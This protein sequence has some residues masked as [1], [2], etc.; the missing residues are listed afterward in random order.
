MQVKQHLQTSGHSIVYAEDILRLNDAVAKPSV[1]TETREVC[2]CLSSLCPQCK[3]TSFELEFLLLL[4]LMHMEVEVALVLFLSIFACHAHQMLSLS[5]TLMLTNSNLC[6]QVDD[7]REVG[8]CIAAQT[9][10]WEGLIESTSVSGSMPRPREPQLLAIAP[11]DAD[12]EVSQLT[13]KREVLII[14][15]LQVCN[16]LLTRARAL[17][18]SVIAGTESGVAAA[19]DHAGLRQGV[20]HAGTRRHGQG[21]DWIPGRRRDVPAHTLQVSAAARRGGASRGQPLVFLMAVSVLCA[22]E[23]V[24]MAVETFRAGAILF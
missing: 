10:V 7:A 13:L 2:L 1:E 3:K 8:R 24:F 21:Q 9:A 23:P 12:G 11:L 19:R 5:L 15:I 14:G 6:M 16:S 20:R 22:V 17:T 4:I 18:G